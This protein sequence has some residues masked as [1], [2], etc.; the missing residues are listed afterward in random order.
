MSP[1]L[2]SNSAVDIAI[3]LAPPAS[4]Q[5]SEFS[6]HLRE[7]RRIWPESGTSVPP[8]NCTRWGSDASFVLFVT[9]A[10]DV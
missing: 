2:N 1:L 4:L 10:A 3:H 9:A 5:F 7:K 6:H 8:E